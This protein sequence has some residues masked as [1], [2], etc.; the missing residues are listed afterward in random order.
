MILNLFLIFIFINEKIICLFPK[1]ILLLLVF[2][3]EKIINLK[4]IY[5]LKQDLKYYYI[6]F[7]FIIIIIM[8]IIIIIL[9]ALE[10]L[11]SL[12]SKYAFCFIY[13]YKKEMRIKIKNMKFYFIFIFQWINEIIINNILLSFSLLYFINYLLPY[14]FKQNIK[15]VFMIFL[16]VLHWW[17]HDNTHINT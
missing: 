2:Y 12:Y 14:A 16:F 9:Y 15:N 6:I 7:I 17:L 5:L 10:Q 11:L 8:I 4:T 13:S 3:L 1:I